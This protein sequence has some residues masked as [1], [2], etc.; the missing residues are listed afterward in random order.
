M[1]AGWHRDVIPRLGMV[2]QCLC[3]FEGKETIVVRLREV[4]GTRS[5]PE[6]EPILHVMSIDPINIIIF[7]A[8]VFYLIPMQELGNEERGG[9]TMNGGHFNTC[10]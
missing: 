4:L 6:S 8:G 2:V 9:R 3:K 10:R 7:A 5:Q 1:G